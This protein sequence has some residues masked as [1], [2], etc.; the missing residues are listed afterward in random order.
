MK[1]NEITIIIEKPIEVVF[2]FTTN[3]KNT[4][5]WIPSI[6]QE[7]A[8][9][10]PPKIGTQY[11]NRSKDSGWDFYKVTKYVQGRIFALS[12]LDDN[13]HV[14]YSFK[15]LNN[16]RTKMTYLEWMNVGELK[17]PFTETILQNL[18]NCLEET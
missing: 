3:P 1:K 11:K 5:V 9:E 10:F 18:K 14:Q 12:D 4:H 16:N 8:D 2:E 6:H 7:V 17:N 13:Y 15:K